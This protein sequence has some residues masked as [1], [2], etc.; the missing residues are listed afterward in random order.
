MR[1]VGPA[2][3]EARPAGQE[4]GLASSGRP[5]PTGY[6]LPASSRRPAAPADLLLLASSGADQL[7]LDQPRSK[8]NKILNRILD[9]FLCRR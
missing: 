6:L 8:S 3:Q 1:G 9:N 5:V 4:A 7:R 2:G